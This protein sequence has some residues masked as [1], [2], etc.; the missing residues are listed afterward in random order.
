MMQWNI[1]IQYVYPVT[2]FIKFTYIEP[3]EANALYKY[4]IVNV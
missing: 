4:D 2:V 3:G 1:L